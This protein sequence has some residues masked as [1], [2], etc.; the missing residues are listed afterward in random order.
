MA[1]L[2]SL[3]LGLG[4][5]L[6]VVVEYLRTSEV[7]RFPTAILASSLVVIGVL[8]AAVGMVLAGVLRGRQETRRLAY[9]QLP[10]LPPS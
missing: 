4:L 3:L 10:A 9:L 2:L 1:S 5:G 6:P 8:L 7:D